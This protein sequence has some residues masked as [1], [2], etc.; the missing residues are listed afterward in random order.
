MGSIKIISGDY[1]NSK[2]GMNS[3]NEDEKST[4]KYSKI[5]I[6]VTIL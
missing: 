5:S 6:K 4:R 1:N 3:I 2:E